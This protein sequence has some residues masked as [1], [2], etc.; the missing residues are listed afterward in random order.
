MDEKKIPLRL[1]EVLDNLIKS[2]GHGIKRF[3]DYY[4]RVDGGKA[5]FIERFFVKTATW[6]VVGSIFVY[7]ALSSNPASERYAREAINECQKDL[8][9]LESLKSSAYV[10]PNKEIRGFVSTEV[11]E[12]KVGSC[13]VNALAALKTY[14]HQRDEVSNRETVLTSNGGVP[15]EDPILISMKKELSAALATYNS[16]ISRLKS[17][18]K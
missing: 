6:I 4:D 3:T 10:R 9:E 11:P 17:Q 13:G 12:S 14:F 7:W 5:S 2:L 16:E 18:V 1:K 8:K 15:A